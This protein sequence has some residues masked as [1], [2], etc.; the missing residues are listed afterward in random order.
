M[1]VLG[2]RVNGVARALVTGRTGVYGLVVADVENPFFSRLVRGAE[3][4]AATAGEMVVVCNT[5]ERPERELRAIELLVE[6]QA[7]AI[8]IAASRLPSQRLLELARRGTRIVV[9][10]RV[11]RHNGIASVVTDDL[12]AMH[13]VIAHLRAAG[14][15][16]PAYLAGPATSFAARARARAFRRL[17]TTFF[18]SEPVRTV[19]GLAPTLQGG[20][21]GVERLMSKWPEV[22]AICTYND[23]MAMG[24][25]EALRGLGLTVPDRVGVVGYDGIPL[26]EM[27]HPPLTTVQQRAYEL[28]AQAIAS[29]RRLTQASSSGEPVLVKMPASLVIRESTRGPGH[30]VVP[31]DASVLPAGG[32][33]VG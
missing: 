7:D 11:I 25:L 18:P 28:G 4:Q 26:T 1:E 10:N 13:A 16:H 24:A 30:P 19:G 29:A 5:D 22:D 8:V 20:R 31:T 21:A 32:A 12:A 2:Y 23:L 14:Y 33:E 17:L 3:E 9:I 15:R 27:T 6:R